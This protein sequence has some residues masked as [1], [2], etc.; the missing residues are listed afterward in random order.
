MFLLVCM[1]ERVK[2]QGVVT[3]VPSVHMISSLT[4]KTSSDL[5]S[6]RNPGAFVAGELHRHV[7]KWEEILTQHPKQ[8]EILS[9]IKYKVNV[10]DFF[11]SPSTGF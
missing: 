2:P 11:H 10:R 8:V 4:A 7:K 3:L 1:I 6:F 5:L 9:Y